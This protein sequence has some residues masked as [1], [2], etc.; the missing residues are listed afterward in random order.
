MNLEHLSKGQ[1]HEEL[2][3]MTE[4]AKRDIIAWK[5]HWLRSVNQDKAR[6]DIIRDLDD[7]SVLLVQDWAMKFNPQKCR[8]SQRDW[9]GKRGVPW[10]VSVAMRK[11]STSNAGK[12]ETFTMCHV[13][14]S[15]SQDSCAVLSVMPDV[16]KDLQ[17]VMP[18]LQRVYYWQD[19]AGCY[20]CGNTIS[21]A[22]MVGK[23][24][25]V[26]VKRMDFCDP[27]GGK[28]A[29][30]R[31]SAAIKSHMKIYL[32]SGNNIETSEET[33]EAILSAGG[34]SSVRVTSCGPPK[35]PA[36]L[37][38]K[39]DG[40]GSISNV[41]YDDKGL[42]VWRAYRIGR[43]K[44][45][46]WDKLN[47]SENSEVPYLTDVNKEGVT[48]SFAPVKSKRKDTVSRQESE[49]DSS[50]ENSSDETETETSNARLF[51]CPEEGCIKCYQRYSNL[52][53]HLD[54][55]KHTRALEREP[56]LD[57]AVY[58]YAERLEVQT[59]GVPCVGNV[60]EVPKQ[61]PLQSTL[62]M[63][64]ALRSSQNRRTRFNVKQKEYLSTKFNIGET[65]GRKADP[66]VV[67][68][69]L[70]HARGNDGER[71]F[72]CDEFLTS[73]QISSFF[74]RLATQKSLLDKDDTE[75]NDDEAAEFESSLED[76]TNQVRREVSLQHPIVFDCHN[77]CDLVKQGKL[78]KFS[79]KM[80]KRL[81]EHF[82]LDVSHITV[83]LKRPYV[84]K[85]STFCSN[86]SCQQ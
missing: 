64:W 35:A 50:S 60:Q 5:S 11:E 70:M 38:I 42:R 1:I 67:A 62:P 78:N 22:H 10:H 17:D 9:F 81:C 31:R 52:Q 27:Q 24:H 84:A 14:R 6:L 26:T 23:H 86:C 54:S 79:I 49:E 21:L 33:K 43:G 40:A 85:L 39:L 71:L 45:T 77:M 8:E 16:L 73:Q 18:H 44:Y 55:G 58:G 59:V 37:N 65:T 2:A 32:N 68:K 75:E 61:V 12:Y 13:F 63:G 20:H 66:V 25:G 53:Q 28:G 72:S 57:Q 46:P 80:L 29:C 41:Q 15:C 76:L 48:A 83:R 36:S 19:N 51:S 47:V 69:E 3:F 7:T 30:D 34:M 56:L 74:S 82:D 4:K